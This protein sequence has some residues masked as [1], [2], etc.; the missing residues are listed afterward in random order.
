MEGSGMGFKI[1]TQKKE[2]IS[3]EK[4]TKL[5]KQKRKLIWDTE[6]IMIYKILQNK[7]VGIKTKIKIYNYINVL[8]FVNPQ[9]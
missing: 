9:T 4:G 1:N 3:H 2:I 7:R 6:P 8:F 5:R